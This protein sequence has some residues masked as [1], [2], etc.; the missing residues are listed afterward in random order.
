MVVP[1]KFVNACAA[2]DDIFIIATIPD[3]LPA[4]AEFTRLYYLNPSTEDVWHYRDWSNHQVVS[5]C[6]RREQ[7]SVKRA[8]CALTG[9][10]DVELANSVGQTYEKIADAGLASERALGDVTRIRE[11]GSTLFVCG[12]SGQVY[13]RDDTGW[14]PIDDELVATGKNALE[15]PQLNAPISNETLRQFTQTLRHLP[16]FND[17]GGSDETD[18]YVC[19]NGGNLFYYDGTSWRKIEIDTDAI[20]T[21]IHCVSSDEVWVVGQDGTVLFGNARTGFRNLGEFFPGGYIWSVRHFGGRV[22][23]GTLH[24]LYTL[25]GSNVRLVSSGK[26]DG[27]AQIIALDS[28]S[29]TILWIATDRHAIR[30]DG[31]TFTF[32]E[33]PDNVNY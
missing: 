31:S 14:T 32:F 27:R 6:L 8:G 22:Y 33:H 29:D 16:N 12:G 5:V 23:L 15:L 10:G 4:G 30:Y 1:I 25:D 17:I 20:L 9:D 28:F 18:V 13:R 21:A 19:G 26:L 11:I 3:G 24:G 7:S 2:S